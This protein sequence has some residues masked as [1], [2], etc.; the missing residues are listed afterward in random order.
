[1]KQQEL[2]NLPGLEPCVKDD[3]HGLVLVAVG[4]CESE[5]FVPGFD[6]ASENLT[7]RTGMGCKTGSANGVQRDRGSD[8]RLG[9][10]R[11]GV[12]FQEWACQV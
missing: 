2:V 1:M 7:T 3:T 4:V 11:H 8:V 6:F 5:D 9:S 10:G 12:V